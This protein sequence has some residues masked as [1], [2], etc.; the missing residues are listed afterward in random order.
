MGLR[1]SLNALEE[2]KISCT[3]QDLNPRP[4]ITLAGERQMKITDRRIKFWEIFSAMSCSY[5]FMC[6]K[7]NYFV[8]I[9]LIDVYVTA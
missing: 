6:V 7:I 4:S 5:D 3:Y 1:A 2:R 9:M 8:A